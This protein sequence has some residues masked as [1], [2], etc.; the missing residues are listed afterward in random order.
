[1]GSLSEMEFESAPKIFVSAV[2]YVH[3]GSGLITSW[4]CMRHTRKNIWQSC[5]GAR[6]TL[7]ELVKELILSSKTPE[8]RVCGG[9]SKE[10]E[11]VQFL[12]QNVSCCSGCGHEGKKKRAIRSLQRD[13]YIKS[14][15]V[16]VPS[17]QNLMKSTY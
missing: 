9:G 8:E 4:E 16:P 11:R 14:S 15:G 2:P 5:A 12:G 17:L 7:R 3:G 10:T 1:M 6:Q 13:L